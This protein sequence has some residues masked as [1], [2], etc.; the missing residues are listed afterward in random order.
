M[1]DLKSWNAPGLR[2]KIYDG[3][4][5]YTYSAMP[6][7][8]ISWSNNGLF[9]LDYL[10][11]FSSLSYVIDLHYGAN[12]SIFDLEGAALGFRRIIFVVH[13]ASNPGV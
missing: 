8:S 13:D 9:T 7:E 1:L 10:T 6:S 4:S 11:G 2:F 3:S 12:T 5:D